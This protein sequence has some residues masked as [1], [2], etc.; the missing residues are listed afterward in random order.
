M[1]VPKLYKGLDRISNDY[2]AAFVATYREAKAAAADPTDIPFSKA[3]LVHHG[4]ELVRHGISKRKLVVKNFPDALY[5]FRARADLPNE[6]L[7]DGHFAIVGRGKGHYAFVRINAANRLLL[8]AK[9]QVE[10]L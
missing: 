5:T 6:I 4:S 8:P 10:K 2:G 3:R 7:K 1:A 9:M